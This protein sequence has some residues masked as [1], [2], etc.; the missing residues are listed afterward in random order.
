VRTFFTICDADE[1]QISVSETYRANSSG[2][3]RTS[4]RGSAPSLGL[5]VIPCD[6]DPGAVVPLDE[7]GQ[8]GMSLL[9]VWGAWSNYC[10]SSGAKRGK[11]EELEKNLRRNIVSDA[12]AEDSQN[13]FKRRWRSNF[14]KI[15]LR[16]SILRIST[17]F[18]DT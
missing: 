5:P 10:P 9:G 13:F 8:S 7:Q 4:P 2:P 18:C 15:T 14:I 17:A 3:L 12:A 1:R 16:G 6:N 11:A